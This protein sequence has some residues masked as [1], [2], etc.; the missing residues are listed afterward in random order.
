MPARSEETNS[1]FR[2]PAFA[3]GIILLV[4]VCALS[5]CASFSEQEA[6]YNDAAVDQ[7]ELA[8]PTTAPM[9]EPSAPSR[10]EPASL[11]DYLHHAASKNAGLAA[12]FHRWQASLARI[13]QA[14]SLP[15]PHVTYTIEKTETHGSPMQQQ[16][17]VAQTFPWFGKRRLQGDATAAAAAAVEQVYQTAKLAL[18]Y[19][20]KTAYYEYW[21]LGQDIALTQQH[22]QLLTHLESVARTRYQAGAAP[23]SALIQAQVELG[24]LDDRLRTLE[25]LRKPLVAKLNAAMNRATHA[26]LPWPRELPESAVSFTDEQAAQ[27]MSADNPDL[28]RLDHVI[29]Q[30]DAN[31]KRARKNYYPDISLGVDV[32]RRG[33]TTMAGS[34][35]SD[36]NSMMA[37]VSI[38]LPLWYGTYRAAEREARL[39]KAAAE[40]ERDDTAIQLEADLALTLHQF[41]DAER[42]IGLYRDTLIPKA[43]QSLKVVQQEFETG[44]TGFITLIDAQRLLLE[45]QL[46]HRRAQ[47][48]RMQRLAQ[49]EMLTGRR[50]TGDR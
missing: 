6:H 10:D 14:K 23:N 33:T 17:G 34:M 30:E 16:M 35:A 19:R 47:A 1:A 43:E 42:K 27:W 37:M 26:L 32:V 29:E 24:K 45:F 18:F 8:T 11:E 50:L 41:R 20:V 2:S 39:G 3:G 9:Q 15:D 5:G 22:I 12:A 40:T 21:Y 49:I 38:N 31:A 7:A 48:D 28:R 46:E 13:P 44:S 4:G 36:K 25:A